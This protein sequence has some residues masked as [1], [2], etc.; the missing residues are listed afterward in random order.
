LEP[1]YE[2]L[3]IWVNQQRRLKACGKIDAERHDQLENLGFS[4]VT[5]T[6]EIKWNEMYQRLKDYHT[7]HGDADVPNGWKDDKTLARWVSRQRQLCKKASITKLHKYLL[8]ELGFTWQHHERGSWDERLAEIA[9]YQAKEGNCEVPFNYPENPKLGRFVNKVRGQRNRG[10]LSV[11][12]IAKLDALGFAW[13]SK[14]RTM[15]DGE[16]ISA[17]WHA[18]Y[19]E[20]LR[21]RETYGDLDVPKK[22]RENPQLGNWVSQQRQN[23]KSKTLHPERHRRLN[24]I[25]FEWRSDSSKKEWITRFEELK[26]YKERFGNYRVPVKWKESPALNYWVRKQR[27]ARKKGNLSAEQVK[28][29]NAISFDWGSDPE[30]IR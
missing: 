25:G 18:R 13:A 9:A 19:D 12:R 20:L 3:L 29:L 16:G 4:W 2:D 11:E 17:E 28:I 26:A 21:Y 23:F 10:T 27:H 30:N 15:I 22:W 1:G 24:E 6:N 8:H 7:R 14:R 5:E